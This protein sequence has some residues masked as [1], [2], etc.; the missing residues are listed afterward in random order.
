MLL[1]LTQIAIARPQMREPAFRS[2]RPADWHQ[3]RRWGM[4]GTA[5]R[6]RLCERTRSEDLGRLK[7]A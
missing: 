2:P 4:T 7:E 1:C 6:C 3:Q 5:L